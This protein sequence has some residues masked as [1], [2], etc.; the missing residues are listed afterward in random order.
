M[1]DRF[2]REARGRRRFTRARSARLRPALHDPDHQ[3]QRS[4]ED[5]GLKQRALELVSEP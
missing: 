5:T 3:V 1:R 4:P 2:G